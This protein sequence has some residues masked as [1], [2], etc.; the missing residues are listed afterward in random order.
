MADLARTAADTQVI[1]APPAAARPRWLQPL[2]IGLALLGGA[3]LVLAV[4]TSLLVCGWWEPRLL[5]QAHDV[6]STW[7]SISWRTDRGCFSQIEYWQACGTQT[8]LRT[9]RVAIVRAEHREK[10]PDLKPDTTYNFRF[11]FSYQAAEEG[12]S[13]ASEVFTFTTRPEIEIFNIHVDE[14]TTKA[15]ITWETNLRTDTT[16]KYGKTDQCEDL[17]TNPDQRSETIHSITIAALAPVTTYHYQILASDPRGRG[18]RKPSEALEF[19]TSQEGGLGTFPVLPNGRVDCSFAD[20]GTLLAP[21]EREKLKAAIQRNTGPR[22]V[23]SA[24]EKKQLLATPTNEYDVDEFNNR[25]QMSRIWLNTLKRQGKPV[26]SFFS[27]PRLLQ[28]LYFTNQKLAVT[29]LD[30]IFMELDALDR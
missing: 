12:E 1:G 24:A 16:V 14:Y 11:L 8:K 13:F 26:D 21:D 17:Q 3:C 2:A 25:I 27:K 20:G 9:R 29:R 18:Q 10:L 22:A 15:V 7:A 6:E 19:R 4:Q 23:L 30:Q 5:E 28:E